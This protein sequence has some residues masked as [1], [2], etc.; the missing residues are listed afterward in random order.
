MLTQYTAPSY[1][2]AQLSQLDLSS[3]YFLGGV[4]VLWM[5][6]LLVNDRSFV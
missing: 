6:I 5:A 1:R 3:H 2:N 4:T